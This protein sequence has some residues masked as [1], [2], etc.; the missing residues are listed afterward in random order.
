MCY[1]PF[2]QIL[3]RFPADKYT[4]A[5]FVGTAFL[6]NFYAVFDLD[7]NS[8][9]RENPLGC[10][11]RKLLIATSGTYPSFGMSPI[12]RASFPRELVYFTW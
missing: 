2:I 1:S 6:K 11:S 10:F 7:E 8:V 9:S 4:Q 3:Q 5:I 12:G